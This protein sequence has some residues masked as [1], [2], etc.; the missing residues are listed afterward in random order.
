MNIVDTDFWFHTIG[1][2]VIHANTRIKDTHEKWTQWQE[3][4]IPVDIYEEWKKSGAFNF[5]CA[6]IMGK[7]WRGKYKGKYLACID[8]DNEKGMREVL[9][10]LGKVDTIEKLSAMTIAEQHLDTKDKAHIYF[11]VEK[12]LSKKS[13]VG[14]PNV[15]NTEIP[16]I[17]VKSEGKHGIMFCSPSIHKNGQPYQI[18]GIDVPKVLD[19]EQSE[20]L[21]K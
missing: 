5:G 16:A 15:K 2:S 14:G 9:S 8:I 6:I 12:P 11:I 4:P 17:E 10:K 1:I 20:I 3:K 19:E 13:G 18:L 7:I 21:E